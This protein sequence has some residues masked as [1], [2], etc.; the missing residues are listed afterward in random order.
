MIPRIFY[1]LCCFFFLSLFVSA[2]ETQSR[3]IIYLKDGSCLKGTVLNKTEAGDLHLQLFNGSEL[4]LEN[5]LISQ[6]KTE[7][8]KQNYLQSG[9]SQA[10]RGLYY[11]IHLN[12][13]GAKGARQEWEPE[14]RRYGAGAHIVGG[15]RF[16]RFIGVGLGLGFDGYGDYFVPLMLD[17]RGIAL[18]KRISPVYAFQ[19]GYGFPAGGE[20]DANGE[21]V[22]VEREGGMMIYPSVGVRFETRRNVAFIFDV[23]AKLQNMTKS[24]QYNWQWWVDPNIY[25]DDIWYRSLAFRFGW[26]F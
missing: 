14:A 19:A 23:G 21:F 18:K 6:V 9:F 20:P 26:E 7:T 24:R 8:R 4:F 22:T 16:N 1:T 10:S 15:Y 25:I 12:F 2:Q 11:G 17:L 13:L 3:N 5:D